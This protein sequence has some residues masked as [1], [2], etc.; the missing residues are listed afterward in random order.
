MSP[1]LGVTEILVI[2]SA[3]PLRS[4]LASLGAIAQ[5]QEQE[6]G[7][8]TRG[9]PLGTSRGEEFVEVAGHLLDDLDSGTRGL[10]A[11]YVSTPANTRGVNS[12][13]LTALSIT[14]AAYD[15]AQE[16]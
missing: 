2:A 15:P 6:S 13:Q 16:S 11:D 12:R 5:A 1:P 8:S 4:T 3:V 14:F 10:T 7:Q 9:L